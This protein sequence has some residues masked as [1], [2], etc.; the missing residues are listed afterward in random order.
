MEGGTP[1][2]KS[3]YQLGVRSGEQ[4]SAIICGRAVFVDQSVD[5][6]SSCEQCWAA[7][8]QHARCKAGRAE[9]MVAGFVLLARVRVTFSFAAGD[10]SALATVRKSC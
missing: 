7:D 4:A 9:W 1:L 3:R 6:R 5:Y 2:L 10:K 8:V